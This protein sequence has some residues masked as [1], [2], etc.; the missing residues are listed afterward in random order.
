MPYIIWVPLV[1]LIT[2]AVT[3]TSYKLNKDSDSIKWFICTWALWSTPL[4]AFIARK[5]KNITIDGLIYDLIMVA[6]F[7][8]FSS[9]LLMRGGVTFSNY[10]IGGIILMVCSIVLFKL[11]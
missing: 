4:W 5:S 1:T 8:I 2:I 6:I 11:G 10:Q 9:I 7:S 3:Y